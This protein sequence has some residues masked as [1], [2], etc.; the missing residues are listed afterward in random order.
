MREN[1]LSAEL[2]GL[3]LGKAVRGAL[4]AAGSAPEQDATIAQKLSYLVNALELID[5][6]GEVAEKHDANDNGRLVTVAMLRVF[7]NFT[8]SLGIR[9]QTLISLLKVFD[10]L[11]GGI[12][13]PLVT[14]NP[15]NNRPRATRSI[16]S[17]RAA[18]AAAFSA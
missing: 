14:P 13:H 18:A 6:V 4:L 3:P 10:G 5:L 2:A 12:S 1:K 11:E 8:Q 9:N 17:V 7:Y 15:P 16:I